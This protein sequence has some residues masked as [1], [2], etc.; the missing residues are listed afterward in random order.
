MLRFCLFLFLLTF[1]NFCYAD[2][3]YYQRYTIF[4]SS[5]GPTLLL[6]T[7]TGRTYLLVTSKS[8][9]TN[10]QQVWQQVLYQDLGKDS[11]EVVPYN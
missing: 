5:S 6:D 10:G 7:K 11:W 4:T 3:L 8:K 1:S 9:L 2:G